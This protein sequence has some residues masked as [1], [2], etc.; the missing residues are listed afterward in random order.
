MLIDML[1]G[2]PHHDLFV[3]VPLHRYLREFAIMFCDHSLL[4][5]V[6]D[7]YHLKIGESG[8]PVAAVERG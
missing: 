2:M 1:S 5:F 7:K 8:L 4:L 3:L 6:D